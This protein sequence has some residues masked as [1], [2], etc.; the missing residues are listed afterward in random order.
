[1]K[2]RSFDILHIGQLPSL[3]SFIPMRFFLFP[4][5][6][7]FLAHCATTPSSRIQS[8]PHLYNALSAKEKRLVAQGR[9]DQGMSSPAVFLA[10]GSPDKKIQG[11]LGRKS[12]ERWIYTSAVPTY[13]WGFSPYM[14]YRWGHSG[15]WRYGGFG[16]EPSI[17]FEQRPTSYVEFIDNK[18]SKWLIQAR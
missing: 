5:F 9:I 10:L 3:T 11:A 7:L 4:I 2:K 18:V 13:Y 8:N 16:F 15:Y 6:L 17:L 14:G 12:F 1:M